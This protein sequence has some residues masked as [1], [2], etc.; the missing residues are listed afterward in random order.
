MSERAADSV[1]AVFREEWGRLLATL[2]RWVGDLDLAEEVAADAMAV[3]LERWPVDGVPDR[4]AAWLLTTARRRAVDLLRRRQTYAAKLAVLKVEA[5]RA[6]SE[7]LG[8]DAAP[9]D[10]FGDDRLQLFFTCCHP[11]LAAEARVALTLRYLAGLSTAEVARAFLVPETTM[12]QRLFRAKRKIREA[13]IPYR[14]PS[15]AQLPTRLPAVL[16]VVYV[17]FTESYAASGGTTLLRP[18]LTDEAVRLARILHRLLPSER[19]V[20]G[21]LALL[22]LVDARRAARVDDSGALVL[23]EDQDRSRWDRTLIEEGRTLVVQAL[24][25]GAP[26]PYA[27]QAAIAALHDE[28]AT[29]ETTDWPQIVCLYDVLRATAPSPVVEL[30]RAVAVAMVDGPE[31]GLALID[32]LAASGELDRYHLLHATRGRLLDRLDRPGQAADAYR[33]ALATVGNEPER[34]FLTRCLEAAER[35][36]AA[37]AERP[38]LGR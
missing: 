31:A 7:R 9:A 6:E 2:V 16:S 15:A 21:L 8:A 4:P 35:A 34:A 11:A 25:G 13:Q 18:E 22:L 30:N 23:L 20:T 17:I 10:V 24:T 37:R 1:E 36:D 38:G 12:A 29:V 19:E 32:D 27:L 14:V 33:R 3:A 5:E 28:S 26:G